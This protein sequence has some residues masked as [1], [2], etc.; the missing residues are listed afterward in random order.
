MLPWNTG[1]VHECGVAA[2]RRAGAGLLLHRRQQHTGD[3]P[4]VRSGA[5]LRESTDDGCGCGVRHTW[6]E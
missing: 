5:T 1:A 4:G 6:R 3:V 2:H